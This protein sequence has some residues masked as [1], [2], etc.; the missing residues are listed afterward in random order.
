MENALGRQLGMSGE[1]KME[2]AIKMDAMDSIILM[3]VASSTCEL[4]LVKMVP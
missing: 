3:M 1:T 4:N 2:D